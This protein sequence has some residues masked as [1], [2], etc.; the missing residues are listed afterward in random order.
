MSLSGRR[1]FWCVAVWSAPG[2]DMIRFGAPSIEVC[3]CAD[4][5]WVVSSGL[6]IW[7]FQGVPVGVC[8]G[9]GTGDLVVSVLWKWSS[10]LQSGNS[11]GVIG[12]LQAYLGD[13]THA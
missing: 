4:P 10:E 1:G 9:V 3:K 11:Q 5:I 8:D 13:Y 2:F 6:M 12:N 7:S